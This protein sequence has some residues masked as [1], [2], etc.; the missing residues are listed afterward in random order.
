MNYRLAQSDTEGTVV[1]RR[2]RAFE[3]LLAVLCLLIG[4][5]MLFPGIALFF[6]PE[7]WPYTPF[8]Y[9]GFGLLFLCGAFLLA[10][11]FVVPDCLIFDNGRCRLTVRE[12][13]R[14][15]TSEAAIPYGEIGGF[16]CLRNPDRRSRGW[17]VVMAKKDG[18]LWTLFEAAR[19]ERARELF[20]RLNSGVMLGADTGEPSPPPESDLFS[21]SAA[22]GATVISW[23]NGHPLRS[24]AVPLLTVASMIMVL[25][26]AWPMS[27]NI[28]FHVIAGIFMI[29]VAALALY[30]TLYNF[31]K[32]RIVTV[33]AAEFRYR[34]EGG[35]LP[36]KGF[37]LPVT[38]IASVLF[39]FSTSRM[40]SLL[41]IVRHA[42]AAT[43]GK[44]ASGDITPADLLQVMM[45]MARM[46]RIDA[47][48]VSTCDRIA[49]ERLL[50][51]ALEERSGRTGL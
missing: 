22:E 49:L 39:Q 28:V 19:E 23:K 27:T 34:E 17:C 1:L 48:T 29:I 3:R 20:N 30:G 35:P 31:G 47:G 5:A 26:G 8:F 38:E 14:R 43:Y 7:A 9:T 46:K 40:E 41:Y 11:R 36:G 4:L 33:T 12:R 25:Y 21:V 51:R 45:T 13:R 24:S 10:T 16:S 37:T 15:T 2:S 32:T 6:V 18:A 44:I 42:E 50:Q